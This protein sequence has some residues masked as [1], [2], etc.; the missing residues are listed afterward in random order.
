LYQTSPWFKVPPN[1]RRDI[2]RLAFGD[3]RLH[4]SLFLE[5]QYPLDDIHESKD[6]QATM[7]WQWFG[8]ICHQLVVPDQLPAPMTS[9]ANHLG[10]W[11]DTCKSGDPL[12]GYMGA[13]G[14]LL[15]CRQK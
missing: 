14:W 8:C 7:E 10:P 3:R 9:G 2:L 11:A 1:I 12:R 5:R 6:I 15:S 4:M 13:M